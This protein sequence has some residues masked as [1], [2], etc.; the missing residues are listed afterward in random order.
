MAFSIDIYKDFG[1]ALL[2]DG[3]AKIIGYNGNDAYVT[4]PSVINGYT[5]TS[6][7]DCAFYNCTSLTSITIPNSVTWIGDY[8]FSGCTS[9]TSITIPNSVTNI[10][11]CAF[12]NCTNLN[13]P[14][15]NYKAFKPNLICK[16]SNYSYQ[17]YLGEW[18]KEETKIKLC[19]KGYHFVKN[20]FDILNYYNGE[21][22]V[23]FVVGLCEVGDKVETDND[24]KN[25]KCVT[26]R[27]KPVK[28]L[29]REE[30]LAVLNGKGI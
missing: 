4:I 26:N 6:I 13:S 14:K 25:S 7:G 21:Y 1:Y 27:I 22:G 28:I 30:F 15:N 2:K 9:L 12:Y 11:E 20:L 10:G 18:S 23:D 8:A 16:G 17:Y 24:S 5:V 29:T 3:A 19:E